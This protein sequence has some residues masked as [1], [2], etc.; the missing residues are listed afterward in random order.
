MNSNNRFVY[1]RQHVYYDINDVCKLGKCKNILDRDNCCIIIIGV[2]TVY[3]ID[4][5]HQCRLL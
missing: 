3:L 1:I 5:N 2:T 4:Y